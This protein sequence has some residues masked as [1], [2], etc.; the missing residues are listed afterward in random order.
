MSN[1][2]VKSLGVD[3]DDFDYDDEYD[4]YDEGAD[5][6]SPEDQ[7][8]LR[9][10]TVQVKQ[11]LGLQYQV[12]DKEIQD[13]LWNYY[14]D[15]EKTVALI[16]SKHKPKA[17]AVKAQNGEFTS[18]IASTTPQLSASKSCSEVPALIASN[19]QIH[20]H[21]VTSRPRTSSMTA[22]GWL[23]PLT[24]V[25]KSSLNR[26]TNPVACLAER[27]RRAK[28]PSWLPWLRSGKRRAHNP[29]LQ[30]KTLGNRPWAKTTLQA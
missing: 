8:Q 30:P 29:L 9:K 20:R 19:A 14:Y 13:A 1:R 3:D 24:G 4:D 5:E 12:S 22:P 6:L 23:F 25:P 28:C 21:L 7:E 10:G 15:V 2:R 27:P 26:C 11:S 18:L 16:K 17:A